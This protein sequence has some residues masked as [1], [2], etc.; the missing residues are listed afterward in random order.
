MVVLGMALCQQVRPPHIAVDWSQRV[1]IAR[2]RVRSVGLLLL[3][4]SQLWLVFVV[5]RLPARAVVNL[6]S[7]PAS[8]ISSF[9]V[10]GGR[11]SLRKDGVVALWLCSQGVLKESAAGDGVRQIGGFVG[12]VTWVHLWN[13]E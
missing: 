11:F 5:F 6:G 8:E 1:G 2:G 4:S 12:D 3:S 9:G 10:R 13:C 7:L